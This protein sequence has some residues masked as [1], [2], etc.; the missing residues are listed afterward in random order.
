MD[1]LKLPYKVR[2]YIKE[3][4]KEIDDC[5]LSAVEGNKKHI[6]I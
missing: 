6:C 3:N 4:K 2:K 1:N 5:I